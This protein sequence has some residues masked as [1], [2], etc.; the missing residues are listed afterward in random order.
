MAAR[1]FEDLRVWQTARDLTRGV[2]RASENQKLRG[3]FALASQMKRAAVSIGS[4]IAEGFERGTRKQQ[5]EYCYTAKGSAAELRSQIITAYDV[6]LINQHVYEWLIDKAELCARQLQAYI[7][8][9]RGTRKTLP[10]PKYL[11]CEDQQG[12]RVP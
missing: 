5:T 9:L 4:N 11:A 12:E 6:G 10:G 7:I 8:H 1:R 2:Y 3:D